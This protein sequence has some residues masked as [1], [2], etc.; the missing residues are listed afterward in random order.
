VDK[1]GGITSHDVVN[2]VRRIF[3]IKRVGHTGTL[4]PMA[5]GVLVLCVGQA[6]RIVEYLTADRK[7]YAA[8][9]T[10]GVST[11]SQDA[12]GRVLR[13][14]D[15][16]HLT[17][18]S[19]EAALGRFRGRIRQIPPMVSAVHHQGKRLYE[20]ARQGGEVEREAREIEI[21]R[22]ELT[23]FESGVYPRTELRVECST[24]TYIRTLAS[25]IGDSLGVGAMLHSLRRTRAG[26]FTISG[27]VTL[28]E[29]EG[30]EGS[31]WKLLAPVEDALTQWPRI[32]LT[33]DQVR[34]VI[35][36]QSLRVPPEGDGPH[37]LMAPTGR[38]IAVAE[39]RDGSL[40]APVKVLVSGTP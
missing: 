32:P 28:E 13:E 17:R 31:Q 39:P 11:D 12:T 38:V 33:E 5:T 40:L 10:F 1:P 16:S 4:D 29:L 2:R 35:Q 23:G 18:E 34:A 26:A 25:D 9:V 24:G 6:T 15:S 36:G 14:T 19:I 20:I 37:L 3:G 8:G 30:S 27:A 22:I 7:E 21:L